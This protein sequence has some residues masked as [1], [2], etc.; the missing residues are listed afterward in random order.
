M[1]EELKQI[2][3][4]QILNIYK[5][6]GLWLDIKNLIQDNTGLTSLGCC[7]LKTSFQKTA[8]RGFRSTRGALAILCS[9][10][11]IYLPE[12]MRRSTFRHTIGGSNE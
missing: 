7:L 8:S 2:K 6:T 3:T 12:R 4:T 5:N 9:C 10:L 1:R 11:I